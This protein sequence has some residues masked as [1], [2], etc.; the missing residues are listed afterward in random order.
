MNAPQ[1]RGTTLL[2]QCLLVKSKVKT[3]T[4]SKS[5]RAKGRHSQRAERQTKIGFG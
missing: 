3:I 5:V 2:T 1:P 4:S